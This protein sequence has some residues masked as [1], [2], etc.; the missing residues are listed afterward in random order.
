MTSF[1]FV[2]PVRVT[3]GPFCLLYDA[4]GEK[5]NGRKCQILIGRMILQTKLPI[6]GGRENTRS[7]F[8][9]S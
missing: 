6:K 2:F 4:V 7:K 5:E 1:A 3:Y 8:K 9:D